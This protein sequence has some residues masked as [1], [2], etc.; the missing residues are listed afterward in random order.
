MRRVE[1][2][3]TTN[4]CLLGIYR[5]ELDKACFAPD[6][7]Y[8]D[9]KDLAQGAFSNKILKERAYEI[10]LTPKYNGYKGN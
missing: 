7:P 3:F 1:D 4:K 10:V 5:K 9:S 8:S 2:L 6:A